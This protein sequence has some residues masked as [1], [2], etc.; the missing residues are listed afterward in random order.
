MHC[1][2]AEPPPSGEVADPSRNIDGPSEFL[3]FSSMLK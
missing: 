1:D 2:P 3:A